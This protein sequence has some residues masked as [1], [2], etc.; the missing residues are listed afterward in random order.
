MES[1]TIFTAIS[2]FIKGLTETKIKAIN[3]AV[4]KINEHTASW[5]N[6]LDGIE[7]TRKED[8]EIG[9][10]IVHSICGRKLS[11]N[12]FDAVVEMCREYI[13]VKESEE[14]ERKWEE[15]QKA[16]RLTEDAEEMESE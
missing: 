7:L 4:E 14:W 9:V 8:R 1:R 11:G 15:E 13:S 3:F 16:K 12:E 6:D 5:Y 10:E 2:M